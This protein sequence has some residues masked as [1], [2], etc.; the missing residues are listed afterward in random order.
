MGGC[1][2]KAVPQRCTACGLWEP[3][4]LV[5]GPKMQ[6][7]YLGVL[8]DTGFK[9][10][11]VLVISVVWGEFW[12]SQPTGSRQRLGF[13]DWSPQ[14]YKLTLHPEKA[15]PQPSCDFSPVLLWGGNRFVAALPA[16][17]PS[18]G[19]IA[20]PKPAPWI[21]WPGTKA[22]Q[23]PR[24]PRPWEKLHM[25]STPHTSPALLMLPSVL[26]IAVQGPKIV[27]VETGSFKTTTGA[28]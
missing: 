23:P 27:E 4:A 14:L 26:G 17:P 7:F 16:K 11:S 20:L 10:V 1:H 18:V 6:L 25:N 21:S 5:W 28:L 15:W 19:T 2:S 3:P 13:Q 9:D 8:D 12:C 24:R 22:A